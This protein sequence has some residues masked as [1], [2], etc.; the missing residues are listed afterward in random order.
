[1]N[2][3]PEGKIRV[4]AHDDV[5]VTRVTVAI[6]DETGRQLEQGEAKLEIGVWWDYRAA[7]QGRV[8]VDACDMAGNVTQRKFESPWKFTRQL[9]N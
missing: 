6:L 4:S 9:S 2:L 8:Q 7:N 5:M 3:S 1:M